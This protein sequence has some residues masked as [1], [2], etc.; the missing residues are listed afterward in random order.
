MLTGHV[1]LPPTNEVWPPKTGLGVRWCPSPPP[2]H[3][4]P[5]ARENY[6]RS[7]VNTAVIEGDDD[8]GMEIMMFNP[9]PSTALVVLTSAFPDYLRFS[10]S[11]KLRLFLTGAAPASP[12]VQ[13]KRSS[14]R[15]LLLL[16]P[17]LCQLLRFQPSNCVGHA[18]AEFEYFIVCTN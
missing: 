15:F 4:P 5:P 3:P 8:G 13:I 9:Q 16:D 17:Q 10:K 11:K 18:C 2:D 12:A 14:P 1:L 7:T 6:H